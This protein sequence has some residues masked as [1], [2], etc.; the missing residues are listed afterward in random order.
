MAAKM[1]QRGGEIETSRMLWTMTLDSTDDK[2]IKENAANHLLALQAEQDLD[3]LARSSTSIAKRPDTTRNLGA[4]CTRE[5]VAGVPVD[6]VGFPY[7]ASLRAARFMSCTRRTEVFSTRAYRPASRPSSNRRW[8]RQLGC[9]DRTVFKT[10]RS[11]G[12]PFGGTIFSKGC[13]F[14]N[15]RQSR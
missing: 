13:L 11:L 14:P 15:R 4:K 3:G 6:P 8:T 12:S 7:V 1:A 9:S 2:M 10:F 5:P